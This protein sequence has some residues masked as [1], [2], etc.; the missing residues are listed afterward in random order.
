MSGREA[1]VEKASREI[2]L[3]ISRVP[4]FSGDVR[5]LGS[6]EL[7]TVLP[8][9]DPSISL[10]ESSKGTAV[11]VSDL[12]RD[13]VYIIERR[14]EPPF[15]SLHTQIL[16]IAEGGFPSGLSE[17]PFKM[18]GADP[19]FLRNGVDGDV[20]GIVFLHPFLGLQYA[21]IAVIFPGAEDRIR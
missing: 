19:R 11:L 5:M 21:R 3:G 4:G 8:G 10:E 17:P 1:S 20:V 9:R 12:E 14:L 18:T 2:I 13:F 16:K 6:R 15:R 7:V